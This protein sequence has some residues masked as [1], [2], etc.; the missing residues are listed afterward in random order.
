MYVKRNIEVRSCNHSCTRKA[1]SVSY[2][3]FVFVAL[4]IQLAMRMRRIVICGLPRSIKF[5]HIFS[6]CKIFEKKITE[7]KM[8]FHI[9][10]YVFLKHVLS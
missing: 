10:Y 4:L 6:K 1:V 9:L 3:Q 5:F 7:Q 2:P 8:C